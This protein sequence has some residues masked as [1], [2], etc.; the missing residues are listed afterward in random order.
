MT[1]PYKKGNWVGNTKAFEVRIGD[2]VHTIYPYTL[3]SVLDVDSTSGDIRV[4][5]LVS[6]DPYIAI[7]DTNVLVTHICE[8]KPDQIERTYFL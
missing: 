7:S 6:G 8:M 1:Y 4:E 2:V 5:W 3:G